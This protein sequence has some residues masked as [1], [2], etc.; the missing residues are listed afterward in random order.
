MKI[1]LI[2]IQANPSEG[3]LAIPLEV[4][5]AAAILNT[6][7]VNKRHFS[8]VKK[9][10]RCLNTDCGMQSRYPHALTSKY[11]LKC[12]L[13]HNISNIQMSIIVFKWVHIHIYMSMRTVDIYTSA[14]SL[15]DVAKLLNSLKINMVL[16]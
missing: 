14:F 6:T 9:S 2:L 3:N 10:I 15:L 16:V 7:E 12:H 1:L 4:K 11:S 13:S 8:M 5:R